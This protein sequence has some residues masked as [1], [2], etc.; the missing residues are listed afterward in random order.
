MEDPAIYR[1]R[2]PY[3]ELSDIQSFLEIT[4]G[5]QIEEVVERGKDIQVYMART[6]YLLAQA[7]RELNA[8]MSSEVMN[9][10]REAA[11]G[12]GASHTAVNALV[13]SA[14]K[15]EQYLVDWIER[16]NRTATHQLD[17]CRT[18]ISLEKE[19]MNQHL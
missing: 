9:I 2:D 14:C 6:G 10:L 5:E 13:K 11:R 3:N 8:A 12:A 15:D 16:M 18:L 17:F 1:T 7:K 4:V 19:R